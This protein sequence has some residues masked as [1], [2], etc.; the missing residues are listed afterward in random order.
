MYYQ[1]RTKNGH[2]KGEYLMRDPEKLDNFYKELCEIHKKSFPDM[3]EGQ[4]LL[5]ALRFISV[6]LHR[7]PLYPESEELMDLF[8]R[9][10]NARSRWYCDWDTL[11]K[12]ND[13][14]EN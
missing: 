3:R 1:F 5:N 9:Y 14:G 6:T 13:S 10:A 11:G 4:F 2:F 12:E 7:D 8:K